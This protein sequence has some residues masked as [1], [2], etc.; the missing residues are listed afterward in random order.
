[1]ISLFYLYSHIDYPINFEEE[2]KEEKWLNAMN[3]EIDVI[4]KNK[5]V[6]LVSLPQG[7]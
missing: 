1:L 4:E 3:E 6:E 2:I 7:K 5:K